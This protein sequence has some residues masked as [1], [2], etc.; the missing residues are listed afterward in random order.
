MRPPSRAGLPPYAFAFHGYCSTAASIAFEGTSDNPGTDDATRTRACATA[1]LDD[2]RPPLGTVRGFA[3]TAATG[4]CFCYNRKSTDLDCDES[5]ERYVQE[6][7]FD[8][9]GPRW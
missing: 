7:S 3:V 8:F 4:R 2:L 1:C 6:A 5:S 9:Y